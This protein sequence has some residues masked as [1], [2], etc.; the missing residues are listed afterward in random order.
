MKKNTKAHASKETGLEVNAEK[1]KIKFHLIIRTNKLFKQGKVQ[2]FGND[3]NKNHIHEEV[4]SRLNLGIACYDSVQNLLSSHSL[5]I[6][7]SIKIYRII[8][9]PIVAMGWTIGVLGFDSWQGL[10]IFLITTASRTAPGPTQ[11]PIQWVLGTLS[12]GVKQTGHEADHSS[13]CS[14]KVKNA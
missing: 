5:P 14:T 3:N 13:P 7:V 1:I 9:L 4:K 8:I 11:P 6:N 2:I 10:G 12:L